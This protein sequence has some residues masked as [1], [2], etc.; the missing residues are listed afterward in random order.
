MHLLERALQAEACPFA[1]SF[2]ASC[3]EDL[4]LGFLVL[5]ELAAGQCSQLNWI[6]SLHFLL[7]VLSFLKACVALHQKLLDALDISIL[8]VFD[9]ALEELEEL[10]L[11]VALS[12]W[13]PLVRWCLPL[14]RV[15]LE[16]CSLILDASF[17]I[18]NLLRF[19]DARLKCKDAGTSR[20]IGSQRQFLCIIL[21]SLGQEEA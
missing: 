1:W 15:L 19:L 5:S 17:L 10:G 18:L 11:F 2:E 20:L 14:P 16:V 8:V 13:T 4:L 3:K 6:L 7:S 12:I 21:A 9:V